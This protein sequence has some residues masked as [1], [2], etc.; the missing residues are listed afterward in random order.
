MFDREAYCSRY[1]MRKQASINKQANIF[2]AFIGGM[3]MLG[4][5]LGSLG[6]GISKHFGGTVG[7]IGTKI[8]NAGTNVMS[9][10]I[11]AAAGGAATAEEGGSKVFGAIKGGLTLA[12]G[13]GLMA[14]SG[15]ISDH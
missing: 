13:G 4:G 12:A 10:G 14:A 7:T 11:D 3:H 9:K 5:A 6:R 1:F 8:K 2:G 15:G